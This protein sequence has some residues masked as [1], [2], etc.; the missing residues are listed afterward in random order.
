MNLGETKKYIDE[1]LGSLGWS[2][3]IDRSGYEKIQ[4]HTQGNEDRVIQL[5]YKLVSLG[6]QRP[7]REI[8]AEVVSAAIDDLTRMSTILESPQGKPARNNNNQD[9]DRLSIDQ[10]AKALE[11][12][13]APELR[14]ERKAAVSN[15]T[16]KSRGNGAQATARKT[17]GSAAL[18]TI[19]IV[20]DS[21]TIR[22]V[23]TRAL[24]K[25]FTIIQAEDGEEAWSHLLSNN[26]IELV[27][28][29]LMM[30]KLDG[31]GLISR[32]R[33][34]RGSP[35]LHAL[36]IIVVT[37][38]EDTNAKLRA[39]VAGANDFITKNTETAELQA[40]VLA[41]YKLAQTLKEAEWKQIASRNS[42]PAMPPKPAGA[43]GSPP[44]MNTPTSPK[45]A[46][47]SRA[48]NIPSQG[49]HS[50]ARK[51]VAPETPEPVHFSV[52][53]L[54]RT[55]ATASRMSRL[56][57]T[58]SMTLT[59]TV[60]VASIMAVIFYFRAG[61]EIADTPTDVAQAG[62]S[63]KSRVEVDP[64]QQ[65]ATKMGSAVP[66]ETANDSPR[67]DVSQN[68]ARGVVTEKSNVAPQGEQPAKPAQEASPEKVS[69]FRPDK[70]AFPAEPAGPTPKTKPPSRVAPAVVA[71]AQAPQAQTPS[72]EQNSAGAA[73]AA[74]SAPTVVAQAQLPK[75]QTPPEEQN[76]AG[77]AAGDTSS[78]IP[79]V[80]QSSQ[81]SAT[82]A[83]S[84]AMPDRTKSDA[85]VATIAST[86]AS[87]RQISQAELV[88]L[89]KRFVF[90]YQAGDIEQF[91]N[92]FASDVR[93][94][95]QTSKAGL[96]ADYEELFNTTDMRQMILGNVTWEVSDNHANGWG[97]FEV[98][99]RK[100]GQ[101]TIKAFNGSLTFQVDKIDG[102]LQIKKL[103]HGQWK[104]GG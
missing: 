48:Q 43:S 17:P 93:T 4:Q 6:S 86:S 65:S 57:S 9:H 102:R 97:N 47:G 39:L 95:D 25:N 61:P 103:Y 92:L 18:P 8:N 64:P 100:A 26:D 68:V 94:N 89:L 42:K 16:T 49:Q 19:L 76:P 35:Q 50:T 75:A 88:T 71:Q 72:Q 99:V 40:R 81:Q 45:T 82:A 104:A 15:A 36:P 44:A 37:T 41:R 55:G 96:R 101:Q 54:N 58:T 24:E 5:Y 60:V 31:F 85:I 51:F 23:V 10:L 66:P 67:A 46:A 20:D 74:V 87:S 29:D 32:I 38:L 83:S 62:A 56:N 14:A 77:A 2:V 1:Q 3:Q 98:K 11:M 84:S 79:S 7:K 52:D 91:L 73:P 33:T 34:D 69:S 27:V 13:A 53:K 12:T 22:A 70:S 59:A 21:P 30:P 90:V 78:P 63:A 80:A 28:T